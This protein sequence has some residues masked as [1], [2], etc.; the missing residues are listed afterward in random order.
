MLIIHLLG[1]EQVFLYIVVIMHSLHL[2][3]IALF[4]QLT[5][6]GAAQQLVPEA[7]EMGD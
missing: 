3:V 2:F 1:F 6:L 7:N 4:V 5:Q